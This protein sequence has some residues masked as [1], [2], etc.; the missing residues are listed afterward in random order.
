MS[1]GEQRMLEIGPYGAIALTFSLLLI[2]N[3][4]RQFQARVEDKN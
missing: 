3:T 4:L 2:Q 1:G